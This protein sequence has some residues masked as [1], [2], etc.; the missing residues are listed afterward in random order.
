MR[1]IGRILA[2]LLIG[3]TVTG[4]VVAEFQNNSCAG[5]IGP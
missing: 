5:T 4:G 2:W 3:L 1:L